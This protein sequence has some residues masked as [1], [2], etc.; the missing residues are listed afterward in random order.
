MGKDNTNKPLV[1]ES[2]KKT[3]QR[4]G[5]S[6]HENTIVNATQKKFLMLPPD[7]YVNKTYVR[8]Y[9]DI[10]EP[11]KDLILFRGGG[12]S[13]RN[14]FSGVPSFTVY[15]ENPGLLDKDVVFKNNNTKQNKVNAYKKLQNLAPLV[16]VKTNCDNR[17][18]RY[19]VKKIK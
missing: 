4:S 5:G 12:T 8:F 1:Y 10:E 9:G 3:G 19:A 18:D 2:I 13:D 15:N 7:T 11:T 16:V 14:K 17:I 6:T